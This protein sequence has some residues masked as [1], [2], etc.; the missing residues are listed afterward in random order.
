M[1]FGSKKDKEDEYEKEVIN[2][3]VHD[4]EEEQKKFLRESEDSLTA[5]K[6][7]V[8]ENCDQ[9]S[10][11]RGKFGNFHRNPIPTNG[12]NGTLMYLSKLISKKTKKK[13]LFHCLG[14]IPNS[15]TGK[16]EIEIY[17]LVDESFEHWDILFID[18]Y[19]PRRSNKSP[20]DYIFEP[21]NKTKGDRNSALGT[22]RFCA[23]F[24]FNLVPM[25]MDEKNPRYAIVEK[26]IER[27]DYIGKNLF[28]IGEQEKKYDAIM[29]M[30]NELKQQEMSD[31]N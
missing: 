22:S 30:L 14:A 11:A 20:D 29:Q 31:D 10:K 4:T 8:G 15:V 3:Q 26:I 17:E 5:K 27:A 9:L 23:N 21:Y 28:R 18:K 2:V 12:N 7:L 13:M 16:E 1:F 19:H 6:A 25:I 24:P